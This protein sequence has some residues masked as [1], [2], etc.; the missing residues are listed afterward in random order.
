MS[1]GFSNAADNAVFAKLAADSTLTG[2]LG[3]TSIYRGLAPENTDPPYVV[4]S[5]LSPSTPVR[6]LG[7]ASVA[8]ENAVYVAKVIAA[9]PSAAA[10][11]TIAARINTVL[12][13]GTLTYTGFTHVRCSR[14]QDIDFEELAPG[15]VR[16]FH[17]GA[18]YRLQAS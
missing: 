6:T 8:Y 3:G 18:A 1:S 5:P 2:L 14:E 15:G 10:A 11:G 16:L 4:F 9:G 12:E 17:R 13:G 7:A